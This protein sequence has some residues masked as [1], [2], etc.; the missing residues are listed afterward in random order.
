MATMRAARRSPLIAV[1]IVALVAMTAVF[2]RQQ[3]ALAGS[4][5]PADKMTVTASNTSVSGPNTDMTLMTA[6]MKTS[7]V[8]DLRL[9]V[10]AECTILSNITNAGTSSSGY[11]AKVDVWVEVDGAPVPV[12]PPASTTGASGTG[13]SGPDDGRVVFCNRE[14]TRNTTFASDSESIKDVESTEQ[15]NAFNWVAM[16][17]GNGIHTIV[18]KA[19]FSDTNQGDAMAHGVVSKRGLTVDTTNY[20][21]SQP[22]A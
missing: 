19:H 4:N 6:R 22:S 14:F 7:T 3:I 16:N 15:A 12:V 21:I 11:Q 9:E 10:T 2:I 1:L 5:M 17:V 8:A 20:F 18:V 13:S